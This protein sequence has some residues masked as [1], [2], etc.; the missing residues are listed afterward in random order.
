M[1]SVTLIDLTKV[2]LSK[3]LIDKKRKRR[4]KYLLEQNKQ[5]MIVATTIE[6]TI[7]KDLTT[8]H[9]DET[10]SPDLTLEEA[11]DI[12][13]CAVCLENKRSVLLMPCRHMATCF[14]CV[15]KLRKSKKCP[16]CKQPF[17][18]HMNVYF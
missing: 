6:N 2:P 14:A 3:T 11:K 4:D 1:S 15:T 12:L 9:E 17:D 18:K 16:I 8:N 13:T 10:L 5:K 7:V